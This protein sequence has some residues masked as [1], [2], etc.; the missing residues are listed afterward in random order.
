MKCGETYSDLLG[1]IPNISF[2]Q[3]MWCSSCYWC[4]LCFCLYFS[5]TLPES[6]FCLFPLIIGMLINTSFEASIVHACASIMM[7]ICNWKILMQWI[8]LCFMYVCVPHYANHTHLIWWLT[9]GGHGHMPLWYLA[10]WSAVL[11]YVCDCLMLENFNPILLWIGIMCLYICSYG[12]LSTK[13]F[14]N[15]WSFHGFFL[16]AFLSF[17]VENFSS[18]LPTPLF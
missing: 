3:W 16:L 8:G 17:L 12:N 13:A 6:S 5:H 1:L 7:Q 11:I 10:S 18:S 14:S 2:D 9:T 15:P 4:P